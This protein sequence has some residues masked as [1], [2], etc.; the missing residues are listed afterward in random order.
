MKIRGNALSLKQAELAMPRM[1]SVQQIQSN[2]ANHSNRRKQ[3]EFTMKPFLPLVLL[4][5]MVLADSI[6]HPQK[7]NGRQRAISPIIPGRS[8]LTC[9]PKSNGQPS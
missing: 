7:R 4:T 1:P 3:D 9:R 5:A 2:C 6:V 8:P